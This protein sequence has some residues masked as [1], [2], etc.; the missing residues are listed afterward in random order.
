MFSCLT[1]KQYLAFAVGCEIK[2][3]NNVWKN[4]TLWKFKFEKHIVY[5]L[6]WNLEKI[7]SLKMY[8]L[9][10][11]FFQTLY[12]HRT[13]LIFRHLHSLCKVNTSKMYPSARITYLSELFFSIFTLWRDLNKWQLNIAYEFKNTFRSNALK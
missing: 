2:G 10:F 11:I 9:C 13:R 6:R 3:K 5:L 12:T 8:I 4:I 7:R 1:V